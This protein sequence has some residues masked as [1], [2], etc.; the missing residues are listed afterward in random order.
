MLAAQVRP[1][2]RHCGSD[3][4]PCPAGLIESLEQEKLYD[5]MGSPLLDQLAFE[6]F[7]NSGD[8]ARHLRRVRPLYRARRDTTLDA[9]AHLLPDARARGEAAGLH[10]HV[11]LPRGVDE[12]RFAAATCERGVL[13]EDGA[14]HWADPEEAPPSM[15]L[16]YSSLSEPEIRRGVAALADALT[17][18][19]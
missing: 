19:R 3:G 9:L 12:L 6:R 16:G 7:V 4:R 10:V 5:D 13:V 11:L 1:S 15:V 2:A 14:W 18:V 17:A 8:F